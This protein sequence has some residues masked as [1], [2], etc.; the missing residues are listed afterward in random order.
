MNDEDLLFFFYKEQNPYIKDMAQNIIERRGAR[1]DLSF[2]KKM[3]CLF[4]SSIGTIYKLLWKQWYGDFPLKDF[5]ESVKQVIFTIEEYEP[6]TCNYF[7]RNSLYLDISKDSINFKFNWLY[8]DQWSRNQ[9]DKYSINIIKR[10][11]KEKEFRNKFLLDVK[12]YG[13]YQGY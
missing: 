10:V 5:D 8:K 4:K 12:K 3:D 7:H 13:F 1:L 11:I 9:Y 6:R 2:I